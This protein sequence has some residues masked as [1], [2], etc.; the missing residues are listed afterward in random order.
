MGNA[1]CPARRLANGITGCIRL[2]ETE[3]FED[4]APASQI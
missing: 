4:L 2:P 1:R 3:V